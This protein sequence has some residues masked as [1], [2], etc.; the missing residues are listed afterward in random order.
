MA[1]PPV[2]L[3][4]QADL[5]TAMTAEKIRELAGP[6]GKPEAYP[7]FIKLVLESGQG[8]ILGRVQRAVSVSSV[9]Q[10]W[11]TNWTDLDKA[12]LR[13]LVLSACIYYVHYYGQK[14]EE[15]PED[16][17]LEFETVKQDAT[18]IG[19]HVGTL[20]SQS[21]AAS[22]TLHRLIPGL[23]AG[24]NVPHFPRSGWRNF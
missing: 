17:R 20:A 9:Y 22:S 5:E 14:G 21:Q 1:V 12:N 18:A 19:N 15:M 23:G 10:H 4:L 11:V 24:H 8:A 7:A 3:V 13:R 16:V 6:K 2:Y